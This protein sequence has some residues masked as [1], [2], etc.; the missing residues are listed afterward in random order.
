MVY[1]TLISNAFELRI[2]L[3]I[4]IRLGMVEKVKRFS[5][6]QPHERL[7]EL[8]NFINVAIFDIATLHAAAESTISCS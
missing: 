2:Y 6:T 1:R 4:Q 8:Y 3:E 7:L 5:C